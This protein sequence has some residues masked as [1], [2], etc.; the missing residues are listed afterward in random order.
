MSEHSTP[1]RM[2]LLARLS[3]M[4]RFAGAEGLGPFSE[5]DVQQIIDAFSAESE[6][7]CDGPD[8]LTGF[9]RKVIRSGDMRSKSPINNDLTRWIDKMHDAVL[10][11]EASGRPGGNLFQ[12]WWGL[13]KQI[14]LAAQRLE[15]RRGASC[16][17][18]MP[19]SACDPQPEGREHKEGDLC[20][21]AWNQLREYLMDH[22]GDI[23]HG[24]NDF[25]NLD[26]VFTDV[27]GRDAEEHVSPF[28]AVGSIS[29]EKS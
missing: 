27:V 20:I 29:K 13:K 11:T 19:G 9:P 8:I 23:A 16:D 22:E 15:G 7:E 6:T 5:R 28:A 10:D 3:D 24:I 1:E 14:E 26:A 4:K 25:G 17:A 18:V 21:M 2:Q 12:V